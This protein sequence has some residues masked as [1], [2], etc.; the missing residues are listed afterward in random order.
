MAPTSVAVAS[1][2]ATQSAAERCRR[3]RLGSMLGR[4]LFR[5]ALRPRALS[6]GGGRLSVAGSATV[7]CMM[8]AVRVPLAPGRKYASPWKGSVETG[9][10][11]ASSVDG[12]TCKTHMTCRITPESA[13]GRTHP[14]AIAATYLVRSMTEKQA[15]S[16]LSHVCH[17][18]G[19][20]AQGSRRPSR[21][22]DLPDEKLH[23]GIV[24][25]M[26][27]IDRSLWR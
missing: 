11:R 2:L 18:S 8:R 22:S 13:S 14:G 19:V 25:F 3:R 9:T 4:R 12:I 7:S 20:S 24:A 15:G 17:Q 26:A 5:P 10:T 6:S 21:L 1:D 16:D 27:L 23:A